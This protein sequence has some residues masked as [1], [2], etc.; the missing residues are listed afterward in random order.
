MIKNRLKK[1]L[2]FFLY[3]TGSTFVARLYNKR[4]GRLPILMYHRVVNPKE[5]KGLKSCLQ[6][7]GMVV[8]EKTFER[9]I[10]Y[11]S[12]RFNV[13]SLGDYMNYRAKNMAIPPHSVVITLDD[14]FRDNY[15]N[16]VSILKKYQVTA[17]FF[18]IGNALT[19]EGDIWIHR[20]YYLLDG[21]DYKKFYIMISK[22]ESLRIKLTSNMDKKK[23]LKR[24]KKFLESS[25]NE[26]KKMFFEQL[27]EKYQAANN[28][29][30]PLYKKEYLK[31]EE[32]VK[33]LKKGFSVGGH[34]LTHQDL[35]NLDYEEK[36]EEIS[37]SRLLLDDIIGKK[38]LPFAYPYGQRFNYDNKTIALL[39]ENK[40]SCGLTTI[41]GLN[42][43]NTDLYELYRIEI[44]E[45]SIYEFVVHIT[46]IMAFI[47][48]VFKR[49]LKNIEV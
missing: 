19:K 11:L 37:G 23:T 1:I 14:G 24:V 40:F 26:Q 4:A 2:C 17:T 3:I 34:S 33:M 36:V 46:G 7:M 47:K 29:A 35:K 25:N 22:K 44:G 41:D 9:H 13:I 42:D 5:F 48:I 10:E 8:T 49:L 28:G 38:Y 32:I 31:K 15:Y 16:A 21:L 45:F 30:E 27:K 39:K 12:N 43:I 18:L 6:L 20:L